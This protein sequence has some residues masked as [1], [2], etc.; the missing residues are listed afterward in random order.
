MAAAKKK[1]IQGVQERTLGIAPQRQPRLA[2][3]LDEAD[4]SVQRHELR[5]H[6]LLRRLHVHERHDGARREALLLLH[7]PPRRRSGD[8]VGCGGG[9]PRVRLQKNVTENASGSLQ[10]VSCA[11][12]LKNMKRMQQKNTHWLLLC[13]SG[14]RSAE[15]SLL[16]PLILPKRALSSSRL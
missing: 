15:N 6:R 4:H 7:R 14:W 10:K 1:K 13:V 8:G 12:S 16:P 9:N 5:R 11:H 3:L 2:V